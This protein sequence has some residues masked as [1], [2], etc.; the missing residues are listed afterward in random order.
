MSEQQSVEIFKGR[1]YLALGLFLLGMAALLGRAAQLELFDR[2]FLQNQA[3]ARHLRVVEIPAH[4]G[5]I[6]DRNGEPL[7]I[8][9]PVDSVWANPQELMLASGELPQLARL[10]GLKTEKLQRLLAKRE[11]REFVYLKRH[12]RPDLARKVMALDLPGVSLQREFHRYYPAGE[13][14]AHLVGM[15]NIDDL[16]QEGLEL[17][18]NESL[19]GEPGA[20]RVVRDGRGRIIEEVELIRAMRPGQPLQLSIDRRIQYLAY[21]E[22][23]AAVKQHKA[24]S[25]SLVLLDVRSGE[26]LA[27]VNQP[28]YN[29]NRRSGQKS[30]ARRNRAVTDVFEPG[31]PIKPFTVASALENRLIKPSTVI[32]T[33]PGYYRI[34]RKTV[35]DF[36]DYGALSIGD[37]LVKSSNV[38]ASKIAQKLES[39]Q[40]WSMLSR[41][42]FGESTASGFPGES[43]GVLSNFHR[44]RKVEHATHSYGYG[45]SVTP[46]QLAHAY[47]VLA[48]DGAQYPVT[49]LKNSE[50]AEGEQVITPQVAR[51]VRNMLEGVVSRKGTGYKAHVVGYRV[52]GK[53]GTV[54]KAVAGGYAEDRYHSVFTGMAP[55]SEPRLVMVVMVNDPRNGDYY[56]GAVA[57]PVFSKVMSGALRLL[58]LP[59]DDMPVRASAS[60][61]KRG[62]A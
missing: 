2:E 6:T 49:L 23:K 55:V 42:G 39:E 20:K 30:S 33:S 40:L 54:H 34:G 44:W 47:S 56:G 29:P 16:G 4:R 17:S 13:V 28:S 10:L 61:E 57:A 31:S 19:R 35:S 8:S 9:T 60:T 15:T 22:L 50:P 27:M 24:T 14:T 32:N 25:G 62:P 3:D 58:G 36:R 51:Q 45:L 48:A 26:V 38:G 11:G 5:M 18:Y 1:R 52:A 53:T 46:L 41:V 59:P 37:V 12:V 7:A 21:R 43:A